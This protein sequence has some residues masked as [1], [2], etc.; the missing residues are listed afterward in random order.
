MEY[1]LIFLLFGLGYALDHVFGTAVFRI[2]GTALLVFYVPGSLVVSTFFRKQLD[3]LERF[4]VSVAISCC[5]LPLV[6]YAAYILLAEPLTTGHLEAL[7]LGTIAVSSLVGVLIRLVRKV[8]HYSGK[9]LGVRLRALII[10]HKV[11]IG[12]G[13][14]FLVFNLLLS[15]IHI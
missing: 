5:G 12:I 4:L 8:P 7:I 10:E 15:L 13:L 3:W 9:E 14:A 1:L 2:P 6:A 11:L